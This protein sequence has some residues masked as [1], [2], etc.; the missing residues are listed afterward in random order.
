LY[1]GLLLD[2]IM[3]LIAQNL[4]TLLRLIA[5]ILVTPA[6][7]IH[8]FDEAKSPGR[9]AWPSQL[10]KMN[11]AIRLLVPPHFGNVLTEL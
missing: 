9:C 4:S 3:I 2:F 11:T 7:H 1:C 10:S 8:N 6:K 5:S